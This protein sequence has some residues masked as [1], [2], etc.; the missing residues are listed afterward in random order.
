MMVTGKMNT[1]GRQR[2]GFK[3]RAQQVF[4]AMDHRRRQVAEQAEGYTQGVQ[5][6]NSTGREK[7]SNVVRVIS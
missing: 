2:A 4:I 1:G 6:G 7:A 3:S 5:K